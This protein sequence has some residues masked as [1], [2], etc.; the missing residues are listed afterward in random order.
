MALWTPPK[1]TVESHPQAQCSNQHSDT[2]SVELLS[3]PPAASQCNMLGK[4]FSV[5]F[6]N[7]TAR[8]TASIRSATD[9]GSMKRLCLSRAGRWRQ[10]V[11]LVRL[12]MQDFMPGQSQSKCHRLGLWAAWQCGHVSMLLSCANG[13]QN[14]SSRR[15]WHHA[16]KDLRGCETHSAC[17][18]TKQRAASPSLVPSA[19]IHAFSRCCNCGRTTSAVYLRAVALRAALVSGE[20][21]E[22]NQSGRA[23]TCRQRSS[24]SMA[25]VHVV[26]CVAAMENTL[27]A[28]C[29]FLVS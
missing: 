6:L 29:L 25:A 14:E 16:R 20:G 26:W 2:A 8:E 12:R 1:R 24:R 9:T 28:W 10:C 18:A 23:G 11:P 3:P 4:A 7:A 15:S 19:C 5:L 27:C 17:A 22:R 21:C 13:Q